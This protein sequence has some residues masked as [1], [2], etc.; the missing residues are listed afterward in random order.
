MKV[1]LYG[2]ENFLLL[3][4]SLFGAYILADLQKEISI[5]GVFGIICVFAVMLFFFLRICSFLRSMLKKF[6]VK[7][8][9]PSIIILTIYWLVFIILFLNGFD[10]DEVMPIMW[11]ALM[12]AGM[13]LG[14]KRIYDFYNLFQKY[15][16]WIKIQH[17]NIVNYQEETDYLERELEKIKESDILE[18]IKDAIMGRDSV[19][20]IMVLHFESIYL[21]VIIMLFMQAYLYY[22][23]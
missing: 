16:P 14:A 1:F 17:N 2:I 13:I 23:V 7:Y 11:T 19:V 9:K 18:I 4:I 6:S 12:A 21:T 10:T 5:G 22:L 8:K 20:P 15:C 3:M